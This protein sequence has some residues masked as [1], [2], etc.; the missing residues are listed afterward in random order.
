MTQYTD[1]VTQRINAFVPRC[2]VDVRM[3]E[4][5][6]EYLHPTRGWKRVSYKRI[7]VKLDGPR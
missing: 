6:V 4:T 3:T 7:G 1:L 5:H 2:A